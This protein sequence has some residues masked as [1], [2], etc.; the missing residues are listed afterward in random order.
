MSMNR[1]DWLQYGLSGLLDKPNEKPTQDVVGSVAPG[2]G[3]ATET[4]A[5]VS[6]T[7][8]QVA[9]GVSSGGFKFSVLHVSLAVS[10]IV[11]L[12]LLKVF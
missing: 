6:A 10:V 12:K 1:K 11:A 8:G 9:P 7:A 5:P 4:T 2:G 3:Y